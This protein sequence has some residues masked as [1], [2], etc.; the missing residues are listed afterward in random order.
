MKLDVISTLRFTSTFSI[1]SP[2]SSE[3]LPAIDALEEAQ[4][5]LLS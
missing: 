2:F 4:T 5:P 1:F 3:T